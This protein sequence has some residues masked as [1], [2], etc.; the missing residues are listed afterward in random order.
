MRHLAYKN[1]E[2]ALRKFATEAGIKIAAMV[3]VSALKGW[4]VVDHHQR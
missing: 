1:I 4:N 3:P 2:A